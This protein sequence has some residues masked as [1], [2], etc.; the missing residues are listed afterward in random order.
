M[1]DPEELIAHVQ[2]ATTDYGQLAQASGGIL[3]AKKCSVYF[4]DYKFIPGCARMKSLQDIPAPRM[5]I[6]EGDAMY[7]SHIIIPQPDGTEIPII[8]HNV[9]TA[10]KMLGVYFSPAGDSPTHVKHM[11]QKGLDWVDCLFTKPVSQGDAWLSF[12]C[13]S[14]QEY[15]GVW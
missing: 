4:L 11:V 14:F 1:T 12:F 2:M 8:T 10:S 3:K 6:S 9:T 5:Y 13:S 7:S 15:C